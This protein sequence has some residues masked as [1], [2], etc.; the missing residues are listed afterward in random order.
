MSDE[1]KQP[2]PGQGVGTPA[3]TASSA[4]QSQEA[5]P[6]A[7][8]PASQQGTAEAKPV[9]TV[10]LAALREELKREIQSQVDKRDAKV[11]EKLSA[12][13]TSIAQ[14][15]AAGKELPESEVKDLR[16]KVAQQARDEA[17]TEEPITP[18]AKDPFDLTQWDQSDPAVQVV[19]QAQTEAKMTINSADPESKMIDR[20]SAAKWIK[21]NLAALEAKSNRLKESPVP[22]NEPKPTA[23][24]AARIPPSGGV[25]TTPAASASDY[26]KGAYK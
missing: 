15:K 25:P 14:L 16:A 4:T 18:Q 26:W 19:L 17:A 21:S 20:S 22:P 6:Q 1:T 13:D 2:V 23:P 10:D 5:V 9:T 7:Q 8:E 12:F 11:R 3:G 24:A